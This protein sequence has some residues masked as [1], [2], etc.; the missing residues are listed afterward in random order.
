MTHTELT[1]R[2]E[3]VFK[4]TQNKEG[5]GKGK[6]IK[7]QDIPQ[8]KADPAQIILENKQKANQQDK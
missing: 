7:G 1:G 3:K 6:V 4:E 2:Y 5:K 8:K